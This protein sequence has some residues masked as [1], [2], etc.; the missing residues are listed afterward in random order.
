VKQKEGKKKKKVKGK[1]EN[2]PVIEEKITVQE[3][4]S[5]EGEI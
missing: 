2:N 3:Y 4:I 1:K 5:E